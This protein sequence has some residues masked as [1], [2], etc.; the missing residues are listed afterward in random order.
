MTRLIGY[1]SISYYDFVAK[2]K[3][4]DDTKFAAVQKGDDF[5]SLGIEIDF[6]ICKKV[7]LFISEL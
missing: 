5:S 6:S 4:L 1:Y 2:F 7:A 3:L